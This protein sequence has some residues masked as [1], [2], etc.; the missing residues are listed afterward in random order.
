[1][2]KFTGFGDESFVLLG[3]E[4]SRI[5]LFK[6][7]PDGVTIPLPKGLFRELQ[8]K[9]ERKLV[10][11]FRSHQSYRSLGSA[12]LTSWLTLCSRLD[13]WPWLG[14]LLHRS[15]EYTMECNDR[16]RRPGCRWSSGGIGKPVIY[17]EMGT[18]KDRVTWHCRMNMD[19]NTI[20]YIFTSSSWQPS[21]TEKHQT[22]DLPAH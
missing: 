4:K 22:W 12:H 5:W 19:N 2:T 10:W 3:Q 9:E 7:I 15:L 20:L 16:Q 21:L 1:M 18:R 17:L 13:P 11:V 8:P 6:R 14:Q